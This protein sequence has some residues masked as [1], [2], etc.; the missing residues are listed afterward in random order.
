MDGREYDAV[1]RVLNNLNVDAVR[2]LTN[3]PAKVEALE[4]L[5]LLE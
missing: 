4:A 5:G 2:L 3:N 1:A